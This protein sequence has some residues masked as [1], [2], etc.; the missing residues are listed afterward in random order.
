MSG[1]IAALRGERV[2]LTGGAGFIGTH[3]AERLLELGCDVVLFDNHRRDSLGAVPALRSNARVSLVSGDI[4]DRATL[5][6]A[7]QGAGIVLHL[8]A[9]AG[10]SSYY[11]EPLRTLEVNVLGT[12]NALEAARAAG[13]RQFVDF[14]TSEVFGP[15]AMWVTEESPHGIGP[16]SDLRWVYATS[17]LVSE[18]F[19]LRF[20]TAHGMATTCVR[21]FNIYG[22]RQT[23]EGA[24]GNFCRAVV[25]GEPLQVY[26]DG[27]AI[28]AWCFVTDIVDGVL[29]TLVSPNAAGKVF[30]LGNPREVETT[31]GLARRVAA[32]RPGTRIE[33]RDVD[34]TD[35]RARIPN[36]DRARSELGFEPRVSLDDGLAQTLAWFEEQRG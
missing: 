29:R 25:N 27:S 21:P 4:L 10:V 14:S 30:N 7:M 28:R 24:I 11:A 8:A 16:V 22:P 36:I 6:A 33:M 18:H 2:L 9:I 23:G 3:L 5:E 32:L 17:K 26:G 1:D 15:D 19:T 34:R 13:V 31:L 12:V 35:V 20:G